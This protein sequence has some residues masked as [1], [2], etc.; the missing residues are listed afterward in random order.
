MQGLKTGG[1]HRGTPN[2]VTAQERA[3]IAE[4]GQTPLNYLLSVL[5]NEALGV[6]ERMEAAKAA[7]PYVHPKLSAITLKGE[8]AI[9]RIERVVIDPADAAKVYAEMIGTRIG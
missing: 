9:K 8:T 3:A 6:G 4:S 1:R 2:R 5:R 7:A